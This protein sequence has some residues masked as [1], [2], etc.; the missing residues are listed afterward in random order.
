MLTRVQPLILIALCHLVCHSSA[1][2]A[3]K[4]DSYH[5][6][7]VC[8]FSYLDNQNILTAKPSM[9]PMHHISERMFKKCKNSSK[10]L[11]DIRYMHSKMCSKLYLNPFQKPCHL[12]SKS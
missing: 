10:L 5:S 2:L 7:A 12:E 9:H 1:N 4:V 11:D 6:R 8:N 3:A